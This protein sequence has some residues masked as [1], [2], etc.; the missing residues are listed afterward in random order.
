MNL[1]LYAGATG[2]EAQQLS[3]NTISNNIA[4]VNTTGFKKSKIEFQD[5]LYQ[6]PRPVGG[7]TGAGNIVPVGIEMGMAP[8]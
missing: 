6:N 1:S 8:W 7:D 5:L 2:M 3:L 4:N